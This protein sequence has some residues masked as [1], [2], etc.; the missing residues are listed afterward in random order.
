MEATVDHVNLDPWQEPGYLESING[1][2]VFDGVD[3]SS[4]ATSLDLHSPFFVFSERRIL[5]TV[6]N[7]RNAFAAHSDNV[8]IAFASK[9]CS[10]DAILEVMKK[11]RVSIEVNSMGELAKARDAGFA[12]RNIVL[13]GVAKS[14]EELV[15]AMSPAIKAINVDSPFELK[16]IIDIVA[17][18]DLSA[19]IVLRLVPEL[20]SGTA[21]GIETASSSTKFGMIDSELAECL[22]MLVDA[23][24]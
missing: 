13:N 16:R 2:L 20:E 5:E 17:G 14:V 21:P 8:T 24:V 1:R 11:T 18:Q 6:E 19:N 15:A 4:L 3:I 22:E 7:L 12:D 10:L 9:A 23:P